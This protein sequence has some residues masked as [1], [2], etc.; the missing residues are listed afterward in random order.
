LSETVAEKIDISHEPDL[1]YVFYPATA[2]NNFGG[3]RFDVILSEHPTRQHYDPESIQVTVA[4]Q[5]DTDPIHIHFTT[6]PG[7][8]RVCPGRILLTDRTG[9]HVTAFCFGG[10][11]HIIH[12][13]PETIC[14]IQSPVSILDL[15]LY[16]STDMLFANEVEILMA[17]RRA[18][19]NPQQPYLFEQHMAQV[20]PA[21]LFAACLD[22][23]AAKF[24][25]MPHVTDPLR[26][27]FVHLLHQEIKSWQQDGR[28]PAPVP[29]LEELL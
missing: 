29:P 28:W 3:T 19:W 11:L 2:E 9:K 12:Q 14:V 24:A 20:D 16:P 25:S 10:D 1:G 18:A 27:H 13:P 26:R 8:F 7:H 23:L 4:R 5:N 21:M 6:P 15:S 22:A 17:Q